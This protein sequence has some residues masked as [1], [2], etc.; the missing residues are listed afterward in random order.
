M[1]KIVKEKDLTCIICPRGCQLHV[2]VADDGEITVTGQTCARGKKYGET[3][4]THPT[5]T[6]TSTVL[7]ADGSMLSVRTSAPI[8]KEK[9]FDCMDRLNLVVVDHDV[10]FGDVIIPN[11]LDTGADLIATGAWKRA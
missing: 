6:L 8:P 1:S 4:L 10:D 5:R 9:L 11:I 7:T 2:T 3:E